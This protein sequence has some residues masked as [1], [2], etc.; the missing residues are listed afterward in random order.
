MN[1]EHESHREAF[2]EQAANDIADKV[3]AFW[4]LHESHKDQT[5]EEQEIKADLI[6]NYLRTD[7][8]EGWE[9]VDEAFTDSDETFGLNRNNSGMRMRRKIFDKLQYRLDVQ[10]DKKKLAESMA[11]I[12]QIAFDE[13]KLNIEREDVDPHLEKAGESIARTLTEICNEQLFNELH[14]QIATSAAEK[15]PALEVLLSDQLTNEIL[16]RYLTAEHLIADES[17]AIYFL[18]RKILKELKNNFYRKVKESNDLTYITLINRSI[19]AID[20]MLK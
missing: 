20:K 11:D 10:V 8:I 5:L 16:N 18:R 6:V 2:F 4:E 9:L 12:I 15:I 7:L 17:A 19:D 3:W 1:F 14:P 13:F